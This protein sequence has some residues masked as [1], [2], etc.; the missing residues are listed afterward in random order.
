MSVGKIS[1]QQKFFHSFFNLTLG[2]IMAGNNRTS[3]VGCFYDFQDLKTCLA[4]SVPAK[5]EKQKITLK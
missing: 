5:E 4:K 3:D 1:C 2:I